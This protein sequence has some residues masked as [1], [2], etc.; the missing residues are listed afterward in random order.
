MGI[1]D[2]VLVPHASG[3]I[4]SLWSAETVQESMSM[5]SCGSRFDGEGHC[6]ECWEFWVIVCVWV[7]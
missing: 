2:C 5:A 4:L 7:N 3:D 6:W 1:A